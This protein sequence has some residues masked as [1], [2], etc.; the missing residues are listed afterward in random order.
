MSVGIEIVMNRWMGV[1][2]M[3][4]FAGLPVR[5]QTSPPGYLPDADRMCKDRLPNVMTYEVWDRVFLSEWEGKP[6]YV[7]VHA[8]YMPD[9]GEFLWKSTALS[10]HGYESEPK[11]KP[12]KAGRACEKTS[13]HIVLLEEG[14]WADFWA[15]RGRTVVFHCSLKFY[16]R[17]KAWA[18]V[19]EHW[20]DGA[21]DARPGAKWVTEILVFNQ[22]GYDFFRPKS[23][24]YDARPY[25]YSSLEG[26]KKKGSNW[27]V[28]LKGADQPNRATILLDRKFNLISVKK[29]APAE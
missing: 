18:Y 28:E 10:E 6:L 16:T 29:N 15:E 5:A 24:L 1:A 14:E 27:E 17:E 2:V 21:D 7:K 9:T 20:Q 4:L 25:T 22:L 19:L 26:V 11:E 8:Y 12:K 23:L 13:G 3:L